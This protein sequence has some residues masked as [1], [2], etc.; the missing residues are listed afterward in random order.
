[1]II[2]YDARDLTIL[3]IAAKLLIEILMWL[4]AWLK[5]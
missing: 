3:M 5:L 2:D 1:L 4:R